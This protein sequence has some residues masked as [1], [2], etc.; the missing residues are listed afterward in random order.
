MFRCGTI[1][2]KTTCKLHIIFVIDKYTVLNNVNVFNL[3][4]QKKSNFL[5][6]TYIQQSSQYKIQPSS[7]MSHQQATQHKRQ[8][9]E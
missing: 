3:A 1:C 2:L 4:C 8:I 5:Q 9:Q 7:D 6:I